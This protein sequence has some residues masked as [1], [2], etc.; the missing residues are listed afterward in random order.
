MNEVI[1][2]GKRDSSVTEQHQSSPAGALKPGSSRSPCQ[3]NRPV[4]FR[5]QRLLGVVPPVR[6]RLGWRL[7]R[8]DGVD[9]EVGTLAQQNPGV[10]SLPD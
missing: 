5:A 3:Q 10:K 6:L 1:L 2:E 7:A 4:R 8:M 9:Q